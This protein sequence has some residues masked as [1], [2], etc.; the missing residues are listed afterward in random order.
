MVRVRQLA[1][2][3]LG[4]GLSG[5]ADRRV[6]E[7]DVT[8]RR[9]PYVGGFCFAWC[10]HRENCQLPPANPDTCRTECVDREIQETFDDPCWTRRI[11]YERCLLDG[12]TCEELAAVDVTVEATARCSHWRNDLERCRHTE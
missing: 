5:C 4:L 12:I 6:V 3:L 2:L 7:D 8:V 9:S 11:E 10:G 1:W